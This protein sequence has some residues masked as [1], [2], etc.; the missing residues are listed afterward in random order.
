MIGA[1][2][3]ASPLLGPAAAGAASAASSAAGAAGA[4]FGDVFAALVGDATKNLKA[5]EATA[6]L[7]VQGKATTQQVV[8]SVM[9]AQQSLQTAIAVRDKAVAA[10]QSLSQMAI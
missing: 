1:V 8:E 10:Y 9:S 3:F 5:G 7:G 4:S 2:S 6:I